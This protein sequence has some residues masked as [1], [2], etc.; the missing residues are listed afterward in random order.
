M[1]SVSVRPPADADATEPTSEQPEPQGF[2]DQNPTGRAEIPTARAL[3][4]RSAVELA[5]KQRAAGHH[6][7]VVAEAARAGQIRLRH[8]HFASRQ[9]AEMVSREIA[10][11]RVPNEVVRVR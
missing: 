8:G 1:F 2:P 5:E 3:P 4:L 9:E 7:H 10:R 6:V 11:L